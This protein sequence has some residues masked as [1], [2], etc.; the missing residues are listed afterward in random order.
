MH[1]SETGKPFENC[2]LF[3]NVTWI[4]SKESRRVSSRLVAGV[5][6]SFSIGLNVVTFFLV[7]VLSKLT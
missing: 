2:I 6:V 4:D 5:K 3:Q 7:E 1:I